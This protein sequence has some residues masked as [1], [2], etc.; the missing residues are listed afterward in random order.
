MAPSDFFWWFNSRWQ[1]RNRAG[2]PNRAPL[3]GKDGNYLRTL[4]AAYAEVGRLSDAVTVAQQATALATMQG[5]TDVSSSEERSG[6][7]QEQ[8]PLSGT[9]RGKINYT[10]HLVSF[11]FSIR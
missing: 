2:R 7:A 5:K 4:V 9:L 3:D 6:A 11:S 1:T 8:V 10:S